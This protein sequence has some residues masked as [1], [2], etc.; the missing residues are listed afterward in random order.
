MDKNVDV[1]EGQGN[2]ADVGSNC[3]SDVVKNNGNGLNASTGKGQW[4]E[5][6]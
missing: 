4:A 5:K 1:A 6:W 3:E 2:V